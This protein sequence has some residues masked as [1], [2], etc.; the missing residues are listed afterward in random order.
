MIAT[1]GVQQVDQILVEQSID[2]LAE[3]GGAGDAVETLQRRVPANHLFAGTNHQQA[4]VE[5]L[6]NVFVESVQPVEL[7]GLEMQLAIEAPVFNRGGG[8]RRYGSDERG[9]LGA[10]RRRTSWGEDAEVAVARTSAS[11]ARD[12][13]QWVECV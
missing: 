4:I 7:G 13:Q 10:E 8:L 2:R 6:E 3:H 11:E 9:V 12:R 1:D 5:G